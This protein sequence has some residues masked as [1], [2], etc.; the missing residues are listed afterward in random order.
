MSS[1]AFS[2]WVPSPSAS[3]PKRIPTI[4]KPNANAPRGDAAPENNANANAFPTNANANANANADPDTINALLDQMNREQQQES[5]SNMVRFEPIEP[6]EN[7]VKANKTPST[8]KS[9]VHPMYGG[10]AETQMQLANYNSVYNQ[11]TDLDGYYKAVSQPSRGT[12]QSAQF[13]RYME[14]LNYLIH[15]LEQQQKEQTSGG[16]EEILLYCL[17]GVF[18]IFV[19]DAFARF[20]K[21]VGAASVRPRYKR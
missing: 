17:F 5:M 16:T 21:N 11:P 15:L 4:G 2:D 6:P 12:Q 7:I 19:I 10:R 18:I 20:G 1:L 14:K 9:P 13:D 3:Q 8:P